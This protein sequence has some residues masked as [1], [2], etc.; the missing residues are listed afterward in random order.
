MKSI[1]KIVSLFLCITIC[2]GCFA[3]TVPS[4]SYAMNNSSSLSTTAISS[5]YNQT[6]NQS[7]YRHDIKT[8]TTSV[9]SG[10]Q[11]S[12]QGV[13]ALTYNRSY[14]PDR[15]LVKYKTD[16]VAAMGGVS[17]VSATLNSNLQATVLAEESTLGLPGIQ[18]VELPNG[19][20]VDAAIQ[21]YT[22]NSTLLTSY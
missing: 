13:N 17:Q 14:L 2:M 12:Q 5:Q 15:V 22:N 21:Y 1:L 8:T 16:T 3:D 4:S 11:V 10:N 6:T 7:N 19:T 20:T 18:L 9:S